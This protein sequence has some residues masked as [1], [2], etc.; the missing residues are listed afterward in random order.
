MWQYVILKFIY[1]IQLYKK[2]VQC[3][4]YVGLS[5][6]A[7]QSNSSNCL[8]LI[9]QKK[10]RNLGTCQKFRNPEV[11]E[12]KNN[13]IMVNITFLIDSYLLLFTM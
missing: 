3:C 1:I 12:Y 4:K 11:L 9:P 7:L 8:V 13:E 10:L 6:L 5:A 2:I